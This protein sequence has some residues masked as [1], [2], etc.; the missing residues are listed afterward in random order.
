MIQDRFTLNRRI[1]GVVALCI[2]LLTAIHSWQ[3]FWSTSTIFPP[4]WTEKKFDSIS[5]GDSVESVID[6]LGLPPELVV[7][8]D[9]LAPS[10]YL[11]SVSRELIARN[12]LRPMVL[13]YTQPSRRFGD[14][15][16]DIEFEAKRGVVSQKHREYY[17]ELW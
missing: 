12:K 10:V 16:V 15:F 13:Q 7:Q 6:I 17:H 4:G 2:S 3:W 8:N 9:D 14:H 1:C 5:V 11:G